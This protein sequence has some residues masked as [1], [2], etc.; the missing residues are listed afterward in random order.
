MKSRSLRS[1]INLVILFTSAVIAVLFGGILYPFEVDRYHAHINN[2]RLLVDSVLNQKMEDLAN[3]LYADQRRALQAS[4]AEICSVEGIE[5]ASVYLPDGRHY[6]STEEQLA[7]A[8]EGWAPQATHSIDGLKTISHKDRSLAVFSR[9]I[10]VIGMKVGEARIFYDLSALRRG[11]LLSSGFFVTLL[12]TM[13]LVMSLLLNVLLS[14]LV[15]KP[16]S[17]LHNAIRGIDEGRLG[18][19]VEISSNDEI[20]ETAEAFNSMSLRLARSQVALKETEEMYRGIFENA[21]EGIFRST[22]GEGRFLTVNPSLARI[23]GYESPGEV[24]AGVESIR[25]ELYANPDDRAKFEEILQREGQV[26]DFETQMFRKDKSTVWVSISARRVHNESG[27]LSYYEGSAIDMTERREKEHAK[28]ESEAARAASKAKSEFLASMS[29]E[30][31]TPMNAILGFTEL[32]CPLVTDPLQKSYLESIKISGKGLMTLIND[33]LD[34]SKIEAGKMEIRR[35]SVNLHRLAEEMSRIFDS[36]MAQRGIRLITRVSPTLPDGLMLDQARLRQ[37]LINL[38]GNAMKFTDSGEVILAMTSLRQ[39]EESGH[40]DLHIAVEDTGIG[41][42]PGVRDLIFESFS[43]VQADVGS[44]VRGG[45]GLGLA[46]T[47]KLVEMMGGSISVGGIQGGGSRF[48]IRLREV[49]VARGGAVLPA[50]NESSE[51]ELRRTGFKLLVADDLKINRELVCELLRGK[52]V[53]I[54]EAENGKAAVE[55]ARSSRPDLILMDIRMPVMDGYGAIRELRN[56]PETRPIP[57]IA[58]TAMAMRED[59]D[60]LLS[61]G[62]DGLLIRPFER[63]R[64]FAELRRF[65]GN[66]SGPAMEA[67]ECVQRCIPSEENEEIAGLAE[68]EYKLVFEALQDRLMTDWDSV[69]QRQNISDI[70]TFAAR[71][72]D[73]GSRYS[74]ECLKSYGDDLLFHARGF[75]IDKILVTLENYPRLVRD[76][77]TLGKPRE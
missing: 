40:L 72:A 30:I 51:V 64:F 62:F 66:D 47:K 69:R 58:V 75:D 41:I 22:A 25:G 55:L 1:K 36:Q 4:L 8:M 44:T 17:A 23:L 46:I 43:Q 39:A 67:L 54:L 7:E 34:L 59:T 33:I 35:E 60:R 2:A 56:E 29:H 3:E 26:V 65:V 21:S 77:E 48:E 19:T 49:P 76:F 28:R 42:H 12:L 10:E 27:G 24:L 20:G 57:V 73:L 70:E 74:V 13:I 52:D 53:T 15:L 37:V 18:E 5:A 32:L 38:L 9:P 63:S 16:V 6:A 45:T 71:I 14:H 50:P 31:R 68:D 61:A 11:I